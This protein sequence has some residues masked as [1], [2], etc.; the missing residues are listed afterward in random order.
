MS[1]NFDPE[2]LHGRLLEKGAAYAEFNYAWEL[3]SETKHT[4]LSRI[5]HGL[6]ESGAARSFTQAMEMARGTAEYEDHIARMC[7]AHQQML[8]AK[9]EYD[10]A[11]AW[12]DAMRTK[13]ANQR[14]ETQV[15]RDIA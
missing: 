8:K 13:A 9:V 10:S 14:M 4:V 3:L 5:A 11:K 6:H 15:L 12:A 2:V 1:I 7:E